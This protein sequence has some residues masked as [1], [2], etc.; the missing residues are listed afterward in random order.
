MMMWMPFFGDVAGYPISSDIFSNIV[1]S[2][3]RKEIHFSGGLIAPGGRFT[4]L[5][6]A[7]S[8]LVPEMQPFDY[9]AVD[10]WFDG[11][12]ADPRLCLVQKD[13]VAA[14]PYNLVNA[15][16]VPPTPSI[17]NPG[18]SASIT[19]SGEFAAIDQG[20]LDVFVIWEPSDVVVLDGQTFT[21]S[22][23]L[24]WSGN[25][26]DARVKEWVGNFNSGPDKPFAVMLTDSGDAALT[27][28]EF[29]STATSAAI[30]D[31]TFDSSQFPP[32]IGRYHIQV[33]GLDPGELVSFS[34][35]GTGGQVLVPEPSSAILGMLGG[36]SLMCARRR[37]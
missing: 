21:Y 37:R 20:H 31:R 16:C 15:Y 29:S 24:S 10:S 8:T 33:T 30:A 35:T 19:A 11:V 17:G 4:D 25:H 6:Y 28:P 26:P 7:D 5:H 9:A 13:P 32:P 1:I 12:P 34:K 23:S 14:Q 27:P 2:A 18:E 3:D 36:L 22:S